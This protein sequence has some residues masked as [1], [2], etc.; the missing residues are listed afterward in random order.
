MKECDKEI[1]GIIKEQQ[2]LEHKLSESNLERKRMENEVKILLLIYALGSS[3]LKNK[4][5]VL[6]F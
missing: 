6:L 5:L 1:S 2:K 3:A 4:F